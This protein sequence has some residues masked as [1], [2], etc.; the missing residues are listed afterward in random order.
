MTGKKIYMVWIVVLLGTAACTLQFPYMWDEG[1]LDYRI[2]FHTDPDDAEVL[3]N[4]EFI[5]LAYEFASEEAPL[6]LTSKDNEL[7]LRKRGYE[8]VSVDLWEYQGVDIHIEETL[9]PIEGYG[10]SPV[11][12]EKPVNERN[13]PKVEEMKEMPPPPPP[14]PEPSAEPVPVTLSIQPVEAAVYL[15]GKFLAVIP[16]N[17][18]ITNLRLAPGEHKVEICKPGF[19]TISNTISLSEGKPLDLVFSLEKTPEK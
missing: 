19:K 8:E 16:E 1:R 3:L 10:D 17:G 18:K 11:E 4:G 13:P 12:E 7:V 15:D 5:G 2:T 14:P 9:T 6:I